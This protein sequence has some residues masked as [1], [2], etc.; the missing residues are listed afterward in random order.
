MSKPETFPIKRALTGF[1]KSA[2]MPHADAERWATNNSAM[3][4]RLVH[5][6]RSKH[7][8]LGPHQL[9]QKIFAE[10]KRFATGKA[11]T[12]NAPPKRKG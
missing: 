11:A 9:R 12:H 8:H 5:T 6:T 4:E 2:G 3:A 1:K 10:L 7:G